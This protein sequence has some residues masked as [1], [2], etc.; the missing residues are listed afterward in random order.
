MHSLTQYLE[1]WRRVA[2]VPA[3]SAA[4]H[5]ADGTL[6]HVQVGAPPG[7]TTF[8]PDAR[9]L[10]GSVGKTLAAAWALAQEAAGLFALDAPVLPAFDRAT[11]T[12]LERLPNAQTLTPRH[13]LNHQSG[14]PRYVFEP[15]FWKRVIDEPDHQWTALERLA[16]VFDRE[17]LFPAGEGWA[18]ADTNYILLAHF[19]E[20][21]S[22]E[23]FEAATQRLFVEPLG[24]HG[25]TPSNRRAIPGLVQA[26]VR[27]FADLGLSGRLLDD[28]GRMSIHPGF[29]GAGGGWATTPSDLARWCRAWFS[30]AAV[31]RPD[32]H[33]LLDGVPADEA[34]FGAGTRYGPGCIR[35]ETRI[36]PLL[37][38]DGVM[39]GFLSTAGYFPELDLAAAIQVN[40]DQTPG[41]PR[42]LV[43]LLV[44]F[45]AEAKGRA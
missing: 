35:R 16:F 4:L 9:F 28:D 34:L 7:A 14:L 15:P 26:E 6:E 17:P 25:F 21:L 45:V 38:H 37:G 22:G 30:G 19:L 33:A 36:G 24:L 11:R 8:G 43:E 3:A 42:P 44:D 12:Q 41:D 39:T 20:V 18:Y 1:A 10:A 13:L 27:M 2:Q 31:P 29:E 23:S 32:I 5:F 40:Q